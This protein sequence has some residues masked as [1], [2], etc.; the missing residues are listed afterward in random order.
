M[1]STILVSI[2][3]ATKNEE[4]NIENCLK[5]IKKQ[6]YPQNKIEIIVVDNN[7]QDKTVQIA[8]KFTK[9][10]YMFGPERS[11]Q[12]NFGMFKKSKGKYVMFLDADMSLDV[13][14]IAKAVQKMNSDKLVALYI[15]EVIIGDSFWSRVK[16]FERSFY[17]QTVID[18][19]RFFKKN[20]FK[21]VGG[22]D[23]KLIACE[24]WDLDKRI[25]KLGKIGIL[26]REG[27]EVI[28]HHDNDFN[29]KRYLLKKNYY[30]K[31]FQ[32]YINKWGK[33]DKD[34]KLQFG[35]W[36]RYFR[37]FLENG[38]WKRFLSKPLYVLGFYLLK[39]WVGIF[40]LFSKL[41]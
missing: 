11:S 23:E 24:D 20:A 17:D 30:S 28:F 25:I 38:K 41:K 37:V 40:Y 15:P 33:N 1:K 8:K 14:T 13:K 21:K 22:F 2:V 4:K 35:F 9:N 16:N 6:T 39:F 10:V 31:S 36:Y 5:S 12:R 7:S 19:L 29:V 34:I 3:I 32:K 26:K 27:N 18:G